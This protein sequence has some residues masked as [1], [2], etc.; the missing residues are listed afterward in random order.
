MSDRILDLSRVKMRS[1]RAQWRFIIQCPDTFSNKGFYYAHF[2]GASDAGPS[3]WSRFIS[4][5]MSTKLPKDCA[6]QNLPDIREAL[7]ISTKLV[8]IYSLFVDRNPNLA[9]LL[10]DVALIFDHAPFDLKAYIVVCFGI[11]A[12]D[13]EEYFSKSKTEVA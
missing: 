8:D 10:F 6:R 4:Q 1:H 9:R 13:L 11:T 7:P 5:V 12:S 3:R 2:L